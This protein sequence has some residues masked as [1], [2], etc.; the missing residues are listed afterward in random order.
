M[1]HITTTIVTA[2][3]M[4]EIASTGAPSASVFEF[5]NVHGGVRTHDWSK[6]TLPEVSARFVGRQRIFLPYF[7]YQ[8][9]QSSY[10]GTLPWGWWYSTPKGGQCKEGMALGQ[11][12]IKH[13]L[14]ANV[15]FVVCKARMAALGSGILVLG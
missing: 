9:P 14:H 2:Q 13:K 8:L 15:T 1:E 12:T 11:L 3:I 4:V 10:P 5:T 7:Y 6:W